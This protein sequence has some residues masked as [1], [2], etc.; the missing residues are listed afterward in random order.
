MRSRKD[1]T[2]LLGGIAWGR[3]C[4]TRA[5]G[6]ARSRWAHAEPRQGSPATPRFAT[7]APRW[8]VGE[9]NGA[10]G[11]YGAAG[12]VG[13]SLDSLTLDSR[14]FWFCYRWSHLFPGIGRVT[15]MELARRGA[16]VIMACRTLE[17]ANKVKGTVS[18]P[19]PP[20]RGTPMNVSNLFPSN[21]QTR[22][23]RRPTTKTSSCRN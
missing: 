10:A 2:L 18:F 4:G 8:P 13:N 16:R 23:L 7:P 15:A 14:Q 17:T 9:C 1:R 3:G 12:K 11:P 5:Q 19:R 20:S 6:A 22:S 21:A